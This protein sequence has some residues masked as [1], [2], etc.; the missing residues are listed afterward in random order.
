LS[1]GAILIFGS[2]GQVARELCARCERFGLPIRPMGRKEAD[3]TNAKD[4]ETAISEVKPSLVVNAAAYTHV[5][6]AEAEAEAAFLANATGPGVIARASAAAEVPLLHISTD[7]VFDGS[8]L[9]AY[10]EDDPIS[11]INIYGKS[12]AKG[13]TLIRSTLREHVILR[14]SWVFGIYG[15]NFLKTMLRLG[16]DRDELRIVADQRGSP[17]GTAELAEAILI[18]ARHLSKR[19]AIWGTYHFCGGGVTSWYGFAEKIFEVQAEL[20]GHRPRL[21]PITTSQ[22]PTA[23]RRPANSQL[24]CTKFAQTFG[25]RA[26]HWQEQTRNVVAALL[27]GIRP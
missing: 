12:K 13:E 8:K 18:V 24:D 14:T 25:V 7:Y 1:R 9:G 23:A 19:Q 20:I 11:P 15:A 5:D 17:T 27:C 4:V 16:Q 26:P 2:E 22:Y 6:R 3:I 21:V 10:L